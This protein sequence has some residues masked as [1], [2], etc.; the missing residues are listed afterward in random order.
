MTFSRILALALAVLA[1]Q[2]LAIGEVSDLAD[3]KTLAAIFEEDQA[4]RSSEFDEIEWDTVNERDA[5]RRSRTLEIIRRGE[6]RTSADFL[7]AAYIFQHGSTV[8]DLRL[9]L[10]LSWIA[11]TIDQDNLEAKWLTASAWDRL[12]KEQGQPQWYGTQ[13][14]KFR[15]SPWQIYKIQKGAVTDQQREEMGVPPLGEIQ[16]GVAEM[17]GE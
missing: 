5:V 10:S 3:N 15:N 7:H 16:R 1:L 8:E 14:E 9:A 13:I 4:D 11:A 17:N 2:S 6:I 12:L